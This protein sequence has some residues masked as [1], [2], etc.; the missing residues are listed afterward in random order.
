MVPLRYWPHSLLMAVLLVWTYRSPS[1]DMLQL[2]HGCLYGVTVG[3]EE[4]PVT[5]CDDADPLNIAK[6]PYIDKVMKLLS[7]KPGKVRFKG[8][9]GLRFSATPDGMA[10]EGDRR[11]LITYPIEVAQ[12]YIAPISHELAH[13][14]QMEMAGG[15][16]PLR[17]TFSS[18]R[19]EL[20]ADFLAGVIFSSSLQNININQFQHNLELMGLY[21][22]L[23]ADAHGTPAQRTSA[24]RWG[25]HLNFDTMNQDIRKVS[26]DFQANIY[27]KVVQ[28]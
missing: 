12:S 23:E 2:S 5:P 26:D 7:I 3:H 18:M 27:G 14:L 20:G 17:K 9:K 24:F 13:V 15:L 22:E 25:V 16:D 6:D 19:V 8:C 1:A 21:V 4:T 28:F 10:K 11:Y